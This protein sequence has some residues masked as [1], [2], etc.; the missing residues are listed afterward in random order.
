MYHAYGAFHSHLPEEL[1]FEDFVTFL[2]KSN[3]ETY[4]QFNKTFEQIDQEES[5][6]EA[7]DANVNH[8]I[9]IVKEALVKV[10]FDSEFTTNDPMTEKLALYMIA[11]RNYLE[12]LSYEELTLSKVNWGLKKISKIE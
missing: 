1:F 3:A 9:N 4:R 11:H 6:P 7:P 8:P 5:Q 12:T 10:T 2:K